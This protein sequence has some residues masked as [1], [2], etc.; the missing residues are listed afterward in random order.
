MQRQLEDNVIE[1]LIKLKQEG[2]S[3]RKIAKQLGCGK[4]SVN[5]YFKKYTQVG[6]ES[7]E[8]KKPKVL[9]IDVE[10]SPTVAAVFG[11]FKQN[12]GQASVIREGGHLLTIAWKWLG[13][14]K[15][16]SERLTMLQ[17]IEGNDLSLVT[18][19]WDL[20]EQADVVI[21]HNINNFDLPVFKTRCVFNQLPAPR[22]VK[23]VDTLNLAKEFRFNSNKLNSLCQA[24]DLGAKIE[25]GGMSLWIRCIHGDD[26]ALEEMEVYNRMDIDLLEELYM[27]LRSY[28]SRHPNFAVELGDKIRC[29]VCC[30]DKVKPTGNLVSTNLSVFE[31]YS[32]ECGSRFK[33]R[34]SITTKSQRLNFL[35]N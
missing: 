24:L 25:T 5:H 7:V 8:V 4:S 3:S 28:S 11:R 1:Q 29:N 31:E 35:S 30:S 13:E 23:T 6:V 2:I 21:G 27:E 22:K 18:T 10:T 19:L 20:V 26:K 16:I 12:I 14:S 17:A 15:V 32:C 33:T 34:Q 9:F